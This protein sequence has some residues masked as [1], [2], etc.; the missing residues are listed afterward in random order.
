[1]ATLFGSL[2]NDRLTATNAPDTILGADGNDVMFGNGGRDHIFGGNGDDVVF[3]GSGNDVIGA[4]AD[5]LNP[6]VLAP[7]DDWV[8]GGGGS[9]RITTGAGNDTL[10]GDSGMDFLQGGIGRDVVNGGSGNDQLFWDEQD[11]SFN[12]GSGT[13]RLRM[14]SSD[15]DLGSAAG[16]RIHSI[17]IIDMTGGTGI[18]DSLTLN[19]AELL[20]VS[21]TRSLKVLGD[22]GDIVDIEGPFNQIGTSG[23]YNVYRLGSAFLLVDTDVT[24]L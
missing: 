3:G 10:F 14:A 8:S 11:G 6:F 5:A 4:D 22:A 17:E 15:L 18:S 20:D 19:K 9:D 21:S 1:M 16:R 12:G 23:N 13:D 7:G 2:L 24:V